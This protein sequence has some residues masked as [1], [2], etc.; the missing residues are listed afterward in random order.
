MPSLF[1]HFIQLTR[2]RHG[3]A[4][5]VAAWSDDKRYLAITRNPQIYG[6]IRMCGAHCRARK[7]ADPTA[8]LKG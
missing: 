6:I 1:A 4:L 3:F 8:M 7:Q 2:P 5:L